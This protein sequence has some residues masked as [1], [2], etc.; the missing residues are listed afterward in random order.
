MVSRP[1]AAGDQDENS[2]YRTVNVKLNKRRY[3]NLKLISTM[4]ETPMQQYLAEAVDEI[5]ERHK[6]LLP[7][8]K[9]R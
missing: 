8:V 4:T 5:I 2:V 3:T 7:N 6:H 1:P 9:A